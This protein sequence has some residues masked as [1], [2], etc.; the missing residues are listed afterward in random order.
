[1]QVPASLPPSLSVPVLRC[2]VCRRCATGQ[3]SQF[4]PANSYTFYPGQ[5][6]VNACVACPDT[7][8]AGGEGVLSCGGGTSTLAA[9]WW[10]DMGSL[11]S[12]PAVYPCDISRGCTGMTYQG[13]ATPQC[14][15]EYQETRLCSVC[16]QG[17]FNLL[18]TCYACGTPKA[19]VST[20]GLHTEPG[21][22]PTQ[23]CPS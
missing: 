8:T 1:M 2:P 5:S 7:A 16:T 11:N 20:P 21:G 19:N 12:T 17:Y 18:G 13:P 22:G 14:G 3:G 9:G 10:L 4:C 15:P 6:S 23:A